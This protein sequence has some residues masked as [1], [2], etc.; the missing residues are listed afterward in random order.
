VELAERNVMIALS[1]TLAHEI[2]QPLAATVNYV[3]AANRLIE[4]DGDPDGV[5]NHLAG[6]RDAAIH[7][8][9]VLANARKLS[10]IFDT[11]RTT[12][13]LSEL[14]KNVRRSLQGRN[15]VVPQLNVTLT[16]A[17]IEV[18]GNET[19]LQYVLTQL[20]ESSVHPERGMHSGS[21]Q[22]TA[23]HEDS[24]TN[25]EISHNQARPSPNAVNRSFEGFSSSDFDRSAIGLANCRA[26]IEAGGGQIAYQEAA[27]GMG[28]FRLQLPKRKAA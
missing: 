2:S 8:G 19:Q 25:I 9:K 13:L 22:L 5:K 24:W 15:P 28:T 12:L 4:R 14:L 16:P 26:I 3:E 17:S 10:A 11:G 27:E 23:W 20:L 6:A 18:F 7:A 21:L 1:S